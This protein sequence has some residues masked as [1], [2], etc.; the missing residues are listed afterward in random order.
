MHNKREK[1]SARCPAGAPDQ[2]GDREV[3]PCEC[4]LAARR[5]AGGTSTEQ[6]STPAERLCGLVEAVREAKA[7][8]AKAKESAGCYCRDDLTCQ[9]CAAV[10]SA[11]SALA[12]LLLADPRYLAVVEAACTYVVEAAKDGMEAVRVIDAFRPHAVLTDLEMPNMNGLELTARLRGQ[13]DTRDLPVIMITSR[14]LD[15][16]R[17]QA[18]LSGVSVYLTKPY[19]DHDLLAHLQAQLE[20]G[21]HVAE[22][23]H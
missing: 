18:E 1:H 21:Q 7:K 13:Q 23:I 6:T 4:G 2:T 10:M 8:E 9:P 22:T 11:E 5:T 16:H 17:R 15:K 19:S 20:G 14:S 12:S 3:W